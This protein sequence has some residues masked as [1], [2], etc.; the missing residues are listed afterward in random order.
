[1]AKQHVRKLTRSGSHSYYL[2]I[3]PEFIRQLKWKER[4]KLVV[5]KSKR[6]ILIRDWKRKGFTLVEVLIVVIILGILASLVVPRLAGRTQEAR[7][8]AARSDIEGGVALAL[9]LYEADTGR[10]PDRLEALVR[11]SGGVTNWKGPYLKKG[12][13]KDPWGNVYIYRFPG[14]R[15]TDY[16]DLFS[17]GPDGQE[18]TEDDIVNWED[19]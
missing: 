10:Y 16:F 1:M 8:A 19:E 17:V 15:N 11:K 9:D 2:L 7:R 13:P 3:P 5:T 4:Q 14:T 6:G 12:L 18:G